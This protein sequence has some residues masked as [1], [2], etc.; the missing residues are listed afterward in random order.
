MIYVSYFHLSLCLTLIMLLAVARFFLCVQTDIFESSSF[1]SSVSLSRFFN[2]C[3]CFIS[4]LLLNFLL[5]HVLIRFEDHILLDSYSRNFKRVMYLPFI[6]PLN[7]CIKYF[8]FKIVFYILVLFY[9]LS[10]YSY[11]VGSGS[12]F[13]AEE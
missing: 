11:S 6:K 12:G 5:L 10:G 2:P 7:A 3:S 8:F 1:F 13:G 4:L 9:P